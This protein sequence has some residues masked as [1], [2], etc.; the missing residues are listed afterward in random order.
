MTR[1]TINR[2]A[3]HLIGFRFFQS[4]GATAYD[5]TGYTATVLDA[6]AAISGKLTVDVPTPSN[7]EVYVALDQTAGAVMPGD[8]GLRV[9]ASDSGGATVASREVTIHV[10]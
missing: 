5:L 1:I 3:D 4:D 8:Y 10:R 7:G 2:G 9:W 6:D